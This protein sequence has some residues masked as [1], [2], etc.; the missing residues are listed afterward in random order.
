MSKLFAGAM[1]VFCRER[2]NS[3][4]GQGEHAWAQWFFK[5]FTKEDG[6]Y[7][8]EIN[9]APVLTRDGRVREYP[10][11]TQV[12]APAC[13][14]CNDEMNRRFEQ[15]PKPVIR[16]VMDTPNGAVELTPQEAGLFGLWWLKTMLV[17]SHEDTVDLAVGVSPARWDLKLV[18]DDLYSWMVTD[19][20]PPGGLSVWVSRRSDTAVPVSSS[21]LTMYLPTVVADGRKAQFMVTQ[22]GVKFLAVTLVYHPGWPIEHPL[23]ATSEAVRI[24]PPSGNSLDLVSLRETTPSA[25]RWRPGDELRF[26][27]GAYGSVALPSLQTFPG[28]YTPG[29]ISGRAPG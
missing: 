19:E 8:I 13:K 12:R 2:P 10:S 17:L 26:A 21:P 25:V 28:P 5:M 22:A 1:C 11:I 16:K 15:H 7:H 6:P 29:V 3:D 14:T 4:K 20:A 27:D 9:G 24:W 18:P 23:E